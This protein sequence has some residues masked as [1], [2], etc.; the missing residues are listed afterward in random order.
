MNYSPEVTANIQSSID[1]FKRKIEM[2]TTNSQ[3]KTECV[4]LIQ[5]AEMSEVY[6]EN[7]QVRLDADAT[8]NKNYEGTK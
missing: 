4:K 6:N 8:I 7:P 5:N 1:Y 3:K 2:N